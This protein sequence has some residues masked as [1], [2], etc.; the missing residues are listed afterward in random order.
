MED[1]CVCDSC[2][3][4]DNCDHW[5]AMYCCTLCR[6]WDEHPDCEHCDPWDI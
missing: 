4:K 2:P 5:D 3:D 1:V 6:S